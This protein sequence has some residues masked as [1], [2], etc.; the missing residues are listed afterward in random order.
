MRAVPRSVT[1]LVHHS[2]H[3]AHSN[4]PRP[5]FVCARASDADNPLIG[6]GSAMSW[7][8]HNSIHRAADI[9]N[10]GAPAPFGTQ[11]GRGCG[12]PKGPGNPERGGVLVNIHAGVDTAQVAPG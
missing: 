11:K 12:F 6:R 4:L 2:E 7:V 9:S 5:S 10:L 3:A 8:D 1:V